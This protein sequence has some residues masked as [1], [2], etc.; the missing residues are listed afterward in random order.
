MGKDYKKLII[1]Y[2]EK[3]GKKVSFDDLR[4]GICVRGENELSSFSMALDELRI[5]GNLY[6][7]HDGY[8]HIFDDRLVIKQGQ[9]YISKNGIG[10]VKVLEGEK[11]VNYM[12][13]N[14]DLNGA[15]PKDIV[16]IR[17]SEKV[18]YG[19]HISKVE[20]IV[21]RDDF[22]E[23]YRY[24]G[25]GIFEPYELPIDMSVIVSEKECRNLVPD[26][27]VLLSVSKDSV[28]IGE[29]TYAVGNLDKVI[30]HINDPKID[31]LAISY[32]YGF[33][34][35]FSDS[36]MRDVAKISTHV[37]D[38]EI[39]GRVDLRDKNVFTIDGKDTKDIDDA[40]SIELDGD[41]IILRVSI[42][43][44]S[45]YLLKYPNL[46]SE[47]VHRGNSAY[48]A[49]SVVPMLPHELSNGICSLNPGV[50][51][52]TKT[53]EMIFDKDGE[54]ID[55]DI[56]KSVINSKKKMNYDDVNSILEDGIVPF[57]Y[58]EF[59]QDLNLMHRLSSLTTI[60][61][62]LKGSLNLSDL[63]L[64][65]HTAIDGTPIQLK[66][67]FQNKGEILIENFMIM[68]NIVVT[69]AYGYLGQPFI[70]RVH[71]KPDLAKLQKAVEILKEQGVFSTHVINSLLAKI[72]RAR[73]KNGDIKPADLCML[74]KESREIGNIDAVSNLLLRS[75][76]KAG[77]SNVNIG[78]FGLAEED[79]SHF[80]SPIRRAADLINHIMIDLMMEMNK[81]EDYEDMMVIQD[82]LDLL[83]KDLAGICEHISSREV[84][85]DEVE[86]EI[87]RLKTV[88][89]FMDN[90]EY[91]EG[92]ILAEILNI[93]KF[94]MVFLV[95]NRI[96][97]NIDSS[98]LGFMGYNYMRNSRT[99][100]RSK[101]NDCFKLGSKF[102]VLDPIASKSHKLIK[103]NAAYTSN[104]Y[105]R[106]MAELEKRKC[107]RRTHVS[108]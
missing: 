70:Y 96:K 85:A 81:T 44:V 5:S 90:I 68:A 53:V 25:D 7:D 50:D 11:E 71:D 35:H 102:Y 59:V 61:R 31:E 2:I 21:K 79:Y 29:K 22:K 20:E 74:L 47:A 92:P 32:K 43:D 36:V 1:E 27:L 87:E 63:E 12:I 108:H 100:V 17:P 19:H 37:L 33:D 41:N 58:E 99:Y 10:Y 30:G 84:A 48:F 91:Y 103:Y 75:M 15:L 16:I 52:L 77:Y 56:Y 6:L 51:R 42:A 83:S 62:S 88:E 54:L 3:D 4:K 14:Q 73:N 57:G 94:G 97:A 64:K 82:K 46:I 76:M 26:M 45:H 66:R 49:D 65:I 98:E 13:Y 78:H 24:I 80:T 18:Y 107:L 60:K 93:N 67:C 72:E 9:I 40:V 55:Y 106:E 38:D 104:E 39:D 101:T 105:E 28:V 8:Y 86:R 69:E 89:Y 34:H 95:D 23:V